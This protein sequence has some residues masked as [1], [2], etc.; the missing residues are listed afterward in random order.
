MIKWLIIIKNNYRDDVR[1]NL[2]YAL[3]DKIKKDGHVRTDLTCV[4]D[5]I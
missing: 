1:L 2:S 4:S 5:N 3:E